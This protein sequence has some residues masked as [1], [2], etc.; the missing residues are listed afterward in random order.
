MPFNVRFHF[1]ILAALATLFV[2]G[3]SAFGVATTVGATGGI[4]A[5]REG[6]FKQTAI[7]TRINLDISELWFKYSTEAFRKLNLTVEQGRV[8]VTG[9]V[10]NPDHRVE[11]IR[12]AW[13]PEGVVQVI[14]EVRVAES[15]GITGFARDSL[16]S[17]NLRRKMIF[18]KE[19]QSINYTID[20]VQG[21]VYLMGIA[22]DR[23]ELNKVIA[24]ARDTSF[25]RQIVSYVKMAGEPIENIGDP[26][27]TQ[28]ADL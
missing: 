1:M 22:Q 14:N 21:T 3:C 15:D 7:D 11:A 8:L 27:V 18:D 25:V 16:I 23:A 17:A 12:L 28:S 2:G 19:I 6:G 4:A 10:Q 24:H 20:T 26:V 13:Q 5:A 9:V